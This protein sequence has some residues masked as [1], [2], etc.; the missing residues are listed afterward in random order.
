[1]EASSLKGLN[2]REISFVSRCSEGC[3]WPGRVGH[4]GPGKDG[5]TIEG[6]LALVLWNQ[7]LSNG[8]V[9]SAR[10]KIEYM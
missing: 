5:T 10:Q 4:G 6:R 1:M 8:W 9:Q 3:K 7:D 2:H